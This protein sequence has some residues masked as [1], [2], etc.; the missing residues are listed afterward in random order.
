VIQSSSPHTI[1]FNSQPFC[2]D[3]TPDGPRPIKNIS[4]HCQRALAT[5]RRLLA[6][7]RI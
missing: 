5:I 3:P 2:T 7:V 4:A 6:Q 1:G